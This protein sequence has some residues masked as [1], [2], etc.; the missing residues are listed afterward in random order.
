LNRYP[1]WATALFLFL[2]TLFIRLPFFFRDYTD[3]DE[4]TFILMGQSIADGYLPY[5]HLWDLK[6]PLLFYIFGAIEAI[7]PH[8]FIAIRFFGVVVVFI[9]SVFLIKIAKNAHLENGFF[10]AL[11]Y[12]I[13]SSELGNLQGLMSEHLAVFFILPGL[14]CLQ[15]KRSIFYFLAAGIF[16]GCALLCKLSYAYA[17][18]ALLICFLFFNWHKSSFARLFK[19]NIVLTIGLLLPFFL[20]SLPFIAEKKLDLF[21]NSVFLAPLEY[22]HA[23]Q[24][25]LLQKIER[26]WWILPI[27][28][29]LSY[30]AIKKLNKENK[31]PFI[32][33]MSIL[34]G[35]IY[36]F[37]SS[38]NVNGHYLIQVFPFIL[39]LLVGS[40]MQKM[41]TVRL[42]YLV[43][44]VVLVSIESLVEYYHLFESY[45][46]NSTFYYRQSFQI[47]NELKRRD[48]DKKTIFFADYHIGYWLLDQYPLTKST[49]HPSNLNRPYLFKYFDVHKN[50]LEELK[51]I[52]E[53]IRPDVVVSKSEKLSFF[54]PDTEE[55]IYF[56]TIM[57]KE[58]TILHQDNDNKIVVWQRNKN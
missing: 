55:N 46:Q 11:F 13:L 50:S 19:L 54:S 57:N 52:M 39:I 38:G 53:S 49:T 7:F 28:L 21:I 18:V 44:F 29:L 14:L 5:D 56:K 10:I 51:Y 12:I 37:F 27:G 48:L 17:I 3:H 34:L 22:S 15:I 4:S 25:S 16:F 8:S 42:R 33:S 6:P 32:A 47:V 41:L 36:T 31:Q 23:Q 9:S 26:T 35:T 43:V 40:A 2:T 58:F 1:H 30:L 20:L 24:Y 45:K